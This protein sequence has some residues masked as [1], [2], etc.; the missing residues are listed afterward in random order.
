MRS[1]TGPVMHS[2]LTIDSGKTQYFI[3]NGTKKML[4]FK[5]TLSDTVGFEGFDFQSYHLP[6]IQAYA[7]PVPNDNPLKTHLDSAV[8]YGTIDFM[9]THHLVGLSIGVVS[10]GHKHFYN[11][12]TVEKGKTQLP[13]SRTGLP[14][15]LR[16][17]A[18]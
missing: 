5:L 9:L 8:H 1:Q 7:A 16:R 3:W 17:L 15:L 12:G 6:Q 10:N 4:T 2:V 13:T 18:R 11:Y 14:Q